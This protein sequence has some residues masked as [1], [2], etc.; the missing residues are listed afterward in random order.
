MRQPL[1]TLLQRNRELSH[2]DVAGNPL[3]ALKK[4]REEVRPPRRTAVARPATTHGHA[5]APRVWANQIIVM[6][7]SLTSLDGSEITATTRAFLENWKASCLFPP[8]GWIVFL[9]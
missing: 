5:H 4:Y 1:R 2:L 6:S 9:H 3:C 8:P 7:R